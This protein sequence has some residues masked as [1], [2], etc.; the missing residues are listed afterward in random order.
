MTAEQ[1]GQSALDGLP[2]R[3]R[4]V[5]KPF[6][7]RL[8]HLLERVF[9]Y[10]MLAVFALVFFAPFYW[11]VTAS[12][13]ETAELRMIPPTWWPQ[14]FTLEHYVTVWTPRFARYFLNTFIYAGGTTVIVLITCPL[15]AFALVKFPSIF[16]NLL[17]GV[18]VATMM[19]P[20]ATYVVPLHGLLVVI[21]RATGIPMLNTYWGM[22]LPWMI[23]PFGV[24]LMR[25]AMFG[26]PD[27]LLDAARIDGSS[28]LGMFWRVVMPLVR[29][30][31][32]TLAIF[33]FIFKY[34]DLLWPLVV[35]T[36]QAMYP[37]TIGL[38]EFIGTF[39]VEYGLFTAASVSA[40]VPV[41]VLYIFLQRYILEGVAL[42]GI[43][44]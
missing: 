21:E 44:G 14:S 15:L 5:E 4:R 13:K 34:D 42:S 2:V 35:A 36:D 16:G 32:V 40:I 33:M 11:V 24:F 1:D 37:L 23:H 27:E 28:T 31:V 26:V 39:F 19:V 8:L 22:I 6:T 20:F 18:I 7:P 43:K 10:G 9:L 17:F 25:Q 3:I 38:V 41:V 30:Y 12:I 29:T